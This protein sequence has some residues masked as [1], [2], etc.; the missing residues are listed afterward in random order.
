MKGYD[1]NKESSFVQYFQY[2]QESIFKC[3]FKEYNRLSKKRF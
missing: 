2:L 3:F 1:Q